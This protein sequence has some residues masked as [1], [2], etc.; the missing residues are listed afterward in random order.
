[1][2]NS[3][4]LITSQPSCS[5]GSFLLQRYA[6][7]PEAS[8]LS[9]IEAQLSGGLRIAQT[10]RANVGDAIALGVGAARARLPR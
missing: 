9:Q 7:K 6:G 8:R 4:R 1:M 5:S 3:Q 2:R 10:L